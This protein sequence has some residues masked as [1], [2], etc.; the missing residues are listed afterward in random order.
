MHT[1]CGSGNWNLNFTS[2]VLDGNKETKR[3]AT[4]NQ[5]FNIGRTWLPYSCTLIFLQIPSIKR[6]GTI[7]RKQEMSTSVQFSPSTNHTGS[8]IWI[9]TNGYDSYISII[10]LVDATFTIKIKPVR[11]K[12]NALSVC[13]AIRDVTLVKRAKN[14]IRF[15]VSSFER[16]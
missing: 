12:I 15:L 14:R 11:L 13:T 16:Y 9:R 7:T 5:P 1:D 3:S 6:Y 8:L 10:H 2:Y 4:R